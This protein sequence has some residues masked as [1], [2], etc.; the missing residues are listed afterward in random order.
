MRIG[1]NLLYLLPGLVGGTETYAAGL[2]QG[3]ANVSTDEEYFVFVNREAA[4]WPLPTKPNIKRFLCP[5][6]GSRRIHRYYYEQVRL[7]FLL[8]KLKIDLVHSLGYVG[9][10]F[11]PCP[12]VVTI[13]DLNYVDLVKTIPIHRRLAL[14]YFSNRAARTA[15]QIITI[16]M[17]S[18]ERLSRTL[19]LSAEK[20]TVTHL[21]PCP[22]MTRPTTESWT[23][24]RNRYGIR[25]PYIVAFGGGPI[26][27]NI[28][29]LIQAFEKTSDQLTH[30]L[31][32][33]GH[34]PPNVDMSI[35]A[36]R[37]KL[38]TRIIA[39]G[40]VPV[41]HIFPLLSH[42]DL[43]VLP[44]LYEGFGLPV[45]EAQQAGVAVACSIAGS[46]PEVAG[47]GAIFFDPKSADDL[48]RTI[49]TIL[50]D[51]EARQ[52]MILRGKENLK[53]FSWEKTAQVTLSVYKKS[54]SNNEGRSSNDSSELI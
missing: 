37:Q 45:L 8:R 38:R 3:L 17:F 2:L 4:D 13:P 30:I 47:Q 11:S 19:K 24:L 25:E 44:S 22:E 42:A 39:T 26:H 33:I 31:V 29:T 41:S 23:E 18:K 43:F 51:T 7:P 50:T 36:R 54:V 9:P 49:Q 48:A 6:R 21:A 34:L 28:I 10:V 14:N 20:I 53:R 16:S 40:Y 1:I 15:K 5:I 12:A 32:L 52:N 35:I 27:K 46:L